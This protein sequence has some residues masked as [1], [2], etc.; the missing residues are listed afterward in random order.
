MAIFTIDLLSGNLLLIKGDFT[1][2]TGIVTWTT[3]ANKPQWLSGITLC[4]FQSGHT[5]GQYLTGWSNLINSSTVAGYGTPI[6]AIMYNTLYGVNAGKNIT[7]GSGNT[8]I[9]YGAL[10]GSTNGKYNVAIGQDTLSRNTNGRYN[11][12]AGYQSLYCNT[13]GYHNV[14]VGWAVLCGNISGNLNVAIGNAAL[15]VNTIGQCNVAI[16]YSAIDD[17]IS[18]TDNVGVGFA[19]LDFNTTGCGNTA[20]GARAIHDNL[21]GNYNAALGCRA[22]T[23]NRTGSSNVAIGYYAGASIYN[24]NCNTFLGNFAGYNSL[25]KI[26]ASNSIAIG[27]GAYTTANNQIVIGNAD[28]AQTLL[29]GITLYAGT[30]AIAPLK[31]TSG[32]SLT[33]PVAGAIEFTTDNY[34]ATITTGTARK[35]IILNDGTNLTSGKI[36]IASTNG[37]LIDG[38]TPLAGTKTYYVSDTNGGI[39]TRKITFING[40][41]TSET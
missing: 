22:L 27:N 23:A 10:S 32:V 38:Q 24:G 25:Q 30:N 4:T 13:I 8:A 11:I 9:G 36:P 5:H 33:T 14:A 40:V 26:N 41:L 39:A 2:N 28:I 29:R 15:K 6:S 21:T 37:R 3:L 19:T 1:G 31:L 16:G 34:F 35:G 7:S 18:G 17:N 12:A 20:I